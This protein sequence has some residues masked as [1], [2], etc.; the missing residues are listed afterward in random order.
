MKKLTYSTRVV[1][2]LAVVDQ[3]RLVLAV[4]E[5]IVGPWP[6]LRTHA[7][8]RL[9]VGDL[10]D[11]VRL[12]HVAADAGH[13]RIGLVLHEQVA[14][15][16]LAVCHRHVDVMQVA[17]VV[18]HLAVGCEMLLRL[19]GQTLGQDLDRLVGEAPASG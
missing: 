6:L 2:D 16:I 8:D 9:G 7:V 3:R 18:R 17:V 12:H 4:A 14:A 11:L 19:L 13:A 10:D 5:Q 15:V 1:E